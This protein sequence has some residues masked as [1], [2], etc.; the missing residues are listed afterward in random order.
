MDLPQ[1]IYYIIPSFNVLAEDLK[2]GFDQILTEAKIL[3]EFKPLF[4]MENLN[5]MNLHS[6][7][8]FD[9]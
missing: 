1:A 2:K 3:G 6:I 4:S 9:F 8:N 5:N 7:H